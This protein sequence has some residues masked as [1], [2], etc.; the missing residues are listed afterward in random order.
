MD[1]LFANY[2]A[3]NIGHIVTAIFTAVITILSTRLN[4]FKTK[5][6]VQ[7]AEEDLDIKKNNLAF[8]QMERAMSRMDLEIKRLAEK[9]RIGEQ[10][11]IT[12]DRELKEM[13]RKKDFELEIAY[14]VIGTDGYI[15]FVSD[16]AYVEIFSFIT[17]D[18]QH[19]MIER[20]LYEYIEEDVA[21]LIDKMTKK[22]MQTERPIAV[23]NVILDK[24]FLPDKKFTLIESINKFNITDKDG[25]T[26]IR[27]GFPIKIEELEFYEEI[28][29][30]E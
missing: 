9:V 7:I 1:E 29:I 17:P 27:V 14:V 5:K 15:E 24:R 28:E 2:V 3:P 19:E 6:D 10:E 20:S 4:I 21:K 25:V 16:K 12:I 26:S 13:K 23:E 8:E 30:M 22:I 11:R 18:K